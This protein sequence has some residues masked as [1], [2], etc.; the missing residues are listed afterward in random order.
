[1]RKPS[2]DVP[3][4]SDLDVPATVPLSVVFRYRHRRHLKAMALGYA[5]AVVMIF[6]AFAMG[7]PFWKI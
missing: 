7:A 6:L 5:I 3:P 1:M 2:P 4:F